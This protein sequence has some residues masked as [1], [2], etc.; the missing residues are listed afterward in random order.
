LE[1]KSLPEAR[2]HPKIIPTPTFRPSAFFTIVYSQK[3]ANDLLTLLRSKHAP[4]EIG[5]VDMSA[6]SF[7]IARDG[8]GGE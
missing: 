1:T 3:Q 5:V 8:G 2:P 4:M 7:E 6:M